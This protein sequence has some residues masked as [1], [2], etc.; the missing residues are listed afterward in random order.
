MQS[1]LLVPISSDIQTIP[2][3]SKT[4]NEAVTDLLLKSTPLLEL[5]LEA[6]PKSPLKSEE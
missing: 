4:V 2:N 6:N 5:I 1:C 3:L